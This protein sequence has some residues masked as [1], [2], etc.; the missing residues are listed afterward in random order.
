L[1]IILAGVL[2][3]GDNMTTTQFIA[4]GF[5]LAGKIVLVAKKKP[6]KLTA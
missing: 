5:V 1:A 2:L 4:A 6:N 3:Y